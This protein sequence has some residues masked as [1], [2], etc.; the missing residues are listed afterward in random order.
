[1]GNPPPGIVVDSVITSHYLYDFYLVPQLVR[2]DT[3]TPTHYIALYDGAD[4]KTDHTQRF[5][6]KLCH[7]YYNWPAVQA[8]WCLVAICDKYLIGYYSHGME[9]LQRDGDILFALVKEFSPIAYKHLL[10]L[11][12]VFILLKL[13]C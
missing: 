1:M 7:L 12:N 5:T 4:V 2:Q 3:V 11:L 13:V 8:F 10:N 9:T 6:Y